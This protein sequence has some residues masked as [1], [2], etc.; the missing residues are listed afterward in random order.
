MQPA[1]SVALPRCSRA[2]TAYSPR[3]PDA[4]VSF[5]YGKWKTR[6][7]A[8]QHAAARQLTIYLRQSRLALQF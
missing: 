3:G 2:I 7:P 8:R 4:L 6:Q 1:Y 5:L